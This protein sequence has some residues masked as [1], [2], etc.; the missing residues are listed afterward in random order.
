MKAQKLTRVL[1]ALYCE[2][3]LIAREAHSMIARI[4]HNHAAGGEAEK[5]Q[6]ALAATFDAKQ[7]KMDYEKRGSSAIIR[8]EGIIGRKFSSCLQSSG[9][10]SVDVLSRVVEDAVAD[11]EVKEIMLVFD[12]PGGV[13][14]GVPEAAETIAKATE[15]KPVMS[16]VDGLCC[17]AAYWLASQADV[18]Y[19][20]PSGE[21]GSIGCYMAL[22][23]SSRNEEMMGMKTVVIKS[24]KYKAT[25]FPGTSLTEEQRDMLQARVTAIADQFR[26]AVHMKRDGK[27]MMIS[28][29]VMQ[30]QSFDAA[31]ARSVGLIDSITT[32][33]EALLDLRELSKQRARR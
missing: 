18:V 16:Y 23:D 14:M 5:A 1:T 32:I 8:V 20:T 6:H 30:G 3:W 24:G 28:D 33:S 4:V 11:A 15:K 2:P 29:E 7:P 17:S 27:H 12:S 19:S 22:L 9:V 26:M 31:Q 25:G 13:A 21:T 10:V